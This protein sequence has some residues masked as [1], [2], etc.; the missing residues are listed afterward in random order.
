MPSEEKWWCDDNE[1]DLS[2]YV[3][4]VEDQTATST[5]AVGVATETTKVS[6][7]DSGKYVVTI[8]KTPLL[9]KRAGIK[10]AVSNYGSWFDSNI[11]R[12]LAFP[13]TTSLV[14]DTIDSIGLGESLAPYSARDP[15]MAELGYT[16]QAI[17]NEAMELRKNGKLD[18]D[19]T[20]DPISAGWLTR[21]WQKAFSNDEEI[22]EANKKSLAEQNE[23]E[24]IQNE[25]Y[26]KY[27]KQQ[28]DA[29][30][31]Q[32]GKIYGEKYDT[33][34]LDKRIMGN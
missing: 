29:V 19:T 30:R 32:N 14:Q 24:R 6:D 17:S 3:M 27:N 18:V 1:E 25:A 7:P 10:Q 28:M 26:Q 34:S 23:L 33:R 8:K 4:G 11:A 31:E 15:L 20:T 22:I 12:D 16:P 5:P 2:G 13:L 21:L 9:D